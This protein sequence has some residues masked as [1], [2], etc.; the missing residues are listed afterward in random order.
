MKVER[1]SKYLVYSSSSVSYGKSNVDL[2][3]FAYNILNLQ[4]FSVAVKKN[5]LCHTKMFGRTNRCTAKAAV[6]MNGIY[7]L[8]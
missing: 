3:S 1:H 2:S 7:Q 5:S 8:I 4:Y 6:R